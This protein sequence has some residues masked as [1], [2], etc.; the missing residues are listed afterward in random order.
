MTRA[1]KPTSEKARDPYGIGPVGPLVGPIVSVVGLILIAV[2]TINLFDYNLPF[3]GSGN[4][5][6]GGNAEAPSRARS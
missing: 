4:G 2:V 5:G 1:V 3:L 6:N